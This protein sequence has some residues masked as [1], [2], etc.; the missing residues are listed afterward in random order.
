MISPNG[1]F[2]QIFIIYAND[3][4]FI[5]TI[6]YF[7]KIC[8]IY[9]SDLF[10]LKVFCYFYKIFVIFPSELFFLGIISASDLLFLWVICYLHCLKNQIHWI[11]I[12]INIWFK[13][14][15][16]M[17]KPTLKLLHCCF[18]HN[19]ATITETSNE[20]NTNFKNILL[21]I[22]FKTRLR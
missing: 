16:Y 18:I 22:I 20:I 14:N 10:F 17:K 21:L 4:W 7:Y 13:C 1:L 12:L 19:S 15:W 6:C 5:Q 9:A 3:L 8:V 2:L 11:S